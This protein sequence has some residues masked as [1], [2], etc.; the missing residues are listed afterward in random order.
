MDESSSERS[1]V[2]VDE[3]LTSERSHGSLITLVGVM[4]SQSIDAPTEGAQAL[5]SPSQKG[6]SVAICERRR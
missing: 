3:V 1:G 6:S 2:N 4:T 5:Y